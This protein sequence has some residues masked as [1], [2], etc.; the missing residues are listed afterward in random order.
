MK[1]KVCEHLN[2]QL[3]TQFH[4]VIKIKWTANLEFIILVIHAPVFADPVTYT[5]CQG[6]GMHVEHTPFQLSVY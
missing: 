4:F 2:H 5:G 1:N 6:V 3:H